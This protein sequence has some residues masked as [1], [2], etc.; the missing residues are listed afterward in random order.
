MK[1]IHHILIL[2]VLLNAGT[3][4]AASDCNITNANSVLDCALKY[5]DIASNQYQNPHHHRRQNH[6]M[7]FSAFP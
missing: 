5:L 6:L 3:S 4:I 7:P 2:L 1:K